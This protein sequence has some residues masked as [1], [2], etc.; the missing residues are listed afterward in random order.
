MRITL[1]TA[2]LVALLGVGCGTYRPVNQPIE[3]WD[4]HGIADNLGLR[5][6]LEGILLSGGIRE[7]LERLGVKHPRFIVVVVVNAQGQTSRGLDLIPGA[8][9]LGAMIG[10]VSGVQIQSYN[11]ETLE[12][13][14]AS[15]ENWARELPPDPEGWAVQTYLIEV[16]FETLADEEE[17]E[18]FNNVVTSF[19]LDDETVD[20]LI[21][22][23]G[24]LLRE[25][26][27]FVRLLADL[28]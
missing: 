19:A 17:R 18:F 13:M 24:R 11:F 2:A 28:R 6:P 23:G 10:S 22:V 20:R 4:E 12:L 15:M 26:P 7:R 27:E 16:A 8:P 21:E 1:A 9:S 25:S 5:G 14:R 3:H